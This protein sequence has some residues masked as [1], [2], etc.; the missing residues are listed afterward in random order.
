LHHTTTEI[1]KSLSG[2]IYAVECVQVNIDLI[3]NV[4]YSS[5]VCDYV[6][7]F[8]VALQL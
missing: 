2:F 8:P 6:I 1:L 3:F 7:K 5:E 4:L